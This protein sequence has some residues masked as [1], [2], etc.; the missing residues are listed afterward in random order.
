[1][2]AAHTAQGRP[3][4]CTPITRERPLSV[5]ATALHAAPAPRERQTDER[6]CSLKREKAERCE[7][8]P[9][10]SSAADR[11]EL[12]A[13][14]ADTRAESRAASQSSPVALCSLR[15]SQ[16][17]R[18]SLLRRSRCGARDLSLSASPLS[19]ALHADLPSLFSF[20]ER[21]SLVAVQASL[22]PPVH[23]TLSG[24]ALRVPRMQ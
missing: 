17:A 18:L 22:L 19:D 11:T 2:N 7:S 6:L 23:R 14:E 10:H 4:T 3:H 9:L 12:S 20:A 8:S 1:M 15:P 24:A 16:H 21:S 13:K 5:R